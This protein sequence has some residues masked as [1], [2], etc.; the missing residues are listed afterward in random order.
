MH[1]LVIAA[2]FFTGAS[3]VGL[4]IVVPA[5]WRERREMARERERLR[6]RFDGRGRRGC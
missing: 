3:I 5:W 1:R 2:A 4:M 6:K